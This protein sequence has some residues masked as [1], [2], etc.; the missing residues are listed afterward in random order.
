MQRRKMMISIGVLAA[1]Q[2]LPGAFRWTDT[3]L[4][5]ECNLW[6][7]DNDAVVL[8]ETDVICV[9]GDE[10]ILAGDMY[11]Y[12]SPIIEENRARIPA[13]QEAK[14][15]ADLTRKVLIQY[16][17]V[18]AL[19]Q[20]FFR[21][22][23]GNLAPAQAKEAQQKIRTK[24]NRIFHEK[25]VPNLL[26]TY[27]V[28]DVLSLEEALRAKSLSLPQLQSQ[29]IERIFAT[30]AERRNVP[31]DVE[32]TR[33]ELLEYYNEHTEEWQQEGRARWRQLT[34][35]FNRY[36]TKEAARAAIEAMGN[37]IFLGGKSFEA[38]AK[39]SSQGFTA[40]NG[41][42]HDWTTQGSLKSKPLDQAIFSIPLNR[43]SLIIED[44]VGFHIIEVLE[45]KD[46]HVTSFSEAQDD[47]RDAIVEQKKNKLRDA[48]RKKV[49][50][51]TPIWTRWPEDIP[52]SRSLEA[53][54]VE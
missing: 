42:L 38:V 49:M 36:P 6:A 28:N 12:V 43:L 35:R 9:V 16:V 22:Q 29:F 15:R 4:Q 32:V 20:D 48:Y 5:S 37:E 30:E 17:E 51:R 11:V 52:G 1:A 2:C 40:P 39:S 50:E 8:K 7:A 44:D 53:V 47:M 18:K 27:K 34:A 14:V 21:Q 46:A 41:G 3:G 25:Q 23:A 31:D 10:H 19:C 26:K 45:R 13:S 33:E 24:A 54:L